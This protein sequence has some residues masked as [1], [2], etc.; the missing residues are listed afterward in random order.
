[1]R[2][3][4][5][6]S[7]GAAL[8]LLM[9]L[10]IGGGAASGLAF[11]IG[12]WYANLAKPSWTPPPWIFGP[13]WTL[14]YALMAVASWRVWRTPPSRQRTAALGWFGAQLALNFAWTPIFFGMR[15]PAIALAEIAVLDVAIVA[16]MAAFRRADRAA[17]LLL[18]PYAAWTAFAT[19][20]NLAI[21][22]LN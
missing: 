6:A 22:R 12:D 7:A 21:W 10:C 5:T 9:V 18:V 1:M 8:G 16:T 14:L 2:D 4:A 17:A 19:A 15:S 11:P 13:A 3:G 20:L